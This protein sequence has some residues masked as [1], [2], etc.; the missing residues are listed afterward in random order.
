MTIARE[1]RRQILLFEREMGALRRNCRPD[2]VYIGVERLHE[3][4]I[5]APPEWDPAHHT[6]CGLRMVPA[7]H[8]RRLSTGRRMPLAPGPTIA[9]LDGMRGSGGTI[10]DRLDAWWPDTAKA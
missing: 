5:E 4:E 3:L 6:L 9:E 7:R 1:I 8:A 2:T 10:P